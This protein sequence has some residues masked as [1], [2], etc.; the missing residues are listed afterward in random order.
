GRGDPVEQPASLLGRDEHADI[1]LFR[2]MKIEKKHAYIRRRGEQYI[3]VNNG[4]PPE[5]TLVNEQ[6]V[7]DSIELDEGDR[8]QLGNVLLRFHMRAAANRP[9]AKRPLP[10]QSAAPVQAQAIQ[11]IP[12]GRPAPD[13]RDPRFRR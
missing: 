2:D 10:Y 1:A 6:P 3:L 9:R 4:A 7:R 11:A 5:N 8:I 12:T 13:P